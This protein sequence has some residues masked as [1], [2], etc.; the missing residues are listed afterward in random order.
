M[1]RR[2]RWWH[3]LQDSKN[4]VRLAVDL[5]NRSGAER[6]LEAFIVHMSLGWLK[7]LQA[8]F[9][10]SGKDIFVRDQRGWRI[11]MPNNGGHRHRGLTDLSEEFF[12]ERDPR[13]A[14]LAF[15]TGLRNQI[16]H[17][18]ER[19]IAA[20][21]SGRTQAYLLNYE[22]TVIE[23][24]G[25]DE[26]LADELRFPLFLSSITGD[27]VD[28]LKRVRER[29]PSGVLEWVQDFDT[30]V[31]A[32]VTSDQGFDFKVYLI[33]HKGAKSEADAAITFVREDELTDEQR[34]LM[35]QVQVIIRD[36]KVPVGGSDEFLPGQVVAQVNARIDREFTVH[37][38]T[39]AWRYFKVR[40]ASDAEDQYATKTDFCHFNKLVGRHVYKSAWI[41]YLVRKLSDH[42]I[43]DEIASLKL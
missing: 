37:M 15:F 33:A 31:E 36:R 11:K 19:D 34:A 20:L 5:Y 40:P 29:V 23:L 32:S 21:V 12:E 10:H 41:D 22:Q 8:H 9:E 17:R 25:N 28:S 14:N 3:V 18:Y 24:F 2:P 13:K 7:L 38:H 39:Q 43:Y 30:S 16:E 27:A 6:Q 26:G 42:D 35:D 4:E 1:A